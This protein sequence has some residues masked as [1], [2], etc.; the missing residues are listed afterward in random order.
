VSVLPACQRRGIGSALIREGISRLKN[1]GARGCCLV[2][3]PA[4]YRRFGIQNVRGLVLEGVPEEVFFAFA[5]DGHI[6]QGVVEFHGGFKADGPGRSV[7][8]G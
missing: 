6:P 4:Y 2:G 3:H 8:T 7:S 5:F 1:L